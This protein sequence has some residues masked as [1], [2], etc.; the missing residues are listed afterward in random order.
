MLFRPEEIHPRLPPGPILWRATH[1][2]VRIAH[3]GLRAYGEYLFIAHHNGKWHTT[4]KTWSIHTNHFPRKQ[5]A[6]RQRLEAS[7]GK[8]FLFTIYG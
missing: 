6:Y 7:L 1:L 3:D 2:T 5:P 4:V 8:P